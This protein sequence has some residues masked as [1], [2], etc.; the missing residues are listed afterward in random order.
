MGALRL[1]QGTT[2]PDKEGV[3]MKATIRCAGVLLGTVLAAAHASAD[4]YWSP[5]YRAP[6][7]VAPD[8][9]GPG[10]YAVGPCG[11]VYGPN[12]WLRPAGEPFVGYPTPPARQFQGPSYPTHPFA[13]GPRDFFMW[14][15]NLEDQMRREQ[16]PNLVP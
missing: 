3:A 4:T 14:R 6:H 15:E 2:T 11:A 12:Y 10:F 13:R 16:R 9:C 7:P 5:V 8:A 1:H